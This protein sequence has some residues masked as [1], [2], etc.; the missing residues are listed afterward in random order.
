[1]PRTQATRQ[2]HGAQRGRSR[3]TAPDPFPESPVSA[4]QNRFPRP[5][6]LNKGR[7][8]GCVVPPSGVRCHVVRGLAASLPGPHG[9]QGM[10]VPRVG[11]CTSHA[12]VTRYTQ[13]TRYAQLCRA[14]PGVPVPSVWPI[15]LQGSNGT[16]LASRQTG[17]GKTHTI[18]VDVDAHGCISEQSG[19]LPR[20]ISELFDF[21]AR[22]SEAISLSSHFQCMR[23]LPSL[24]HGAKFCEG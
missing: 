2:P 7:R 13:V 24:T 3:M 19:I 18:L 9:Q 12:Q 1:M 5:Q 4:S 22:R 21:K 11:L 16:I 15:S 20:V 10:C 6:P 8:F 17:S 23:M 14:I